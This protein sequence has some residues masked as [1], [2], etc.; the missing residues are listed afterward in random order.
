MAESKARLM[1]RFWREIAIVLAAKAVALAAIYFLFFAS[2][3][4]YDIAGE[5]FTTDHRP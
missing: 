2:P 5:L 3:P 1:R 4:P